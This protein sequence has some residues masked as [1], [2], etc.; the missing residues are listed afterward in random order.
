LSSYSPCNLYFLGTYGLQQGQIVYK[1]PDPYSL[2]N[3]FK[4][5][6]PFK[7]IIFYDRI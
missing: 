4:H 2:L 3:Y 7:K 6:F 1:G 5:K